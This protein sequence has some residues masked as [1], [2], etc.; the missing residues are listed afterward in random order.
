MVVGDGNSVSCCSCGYG[1]MVRGGGG[2]VWLF[3]IDFLCS[4]YIII[5]MSNL[6]YLNEMVKNIEVLMFDVS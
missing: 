6:Y 4:C 2:G 5:L 1:A 3:A